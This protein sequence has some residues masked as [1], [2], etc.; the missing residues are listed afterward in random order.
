MLQMLQHACVSFDQVHGLR[1][2]TYNPELT[3]KLKVQEHSFSNAAHAAARRCKLRSDS[4]A[5]ECDL[6]LRADHTTP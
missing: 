1:S 4:R 2:V 6:K 3:E 5:R